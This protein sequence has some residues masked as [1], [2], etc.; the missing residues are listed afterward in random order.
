MH[1]RFGPG[2]RPP[3]TAYRDRGWDDPDVA[4]FDIAGLPLRPSDG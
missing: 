4:R 1:I 2:R 3:G